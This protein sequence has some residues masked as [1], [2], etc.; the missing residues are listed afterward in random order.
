MYV[1]YVYGG[2]DRQIRFR[3]ASGTFIL[4]IWYTLVVSIISYANY[5]FSFP[6]YKVDGSWSVFSPYGNCSKD[7]GLGKQ[8]RQRSCTNPSPAHGG[9]KCIGEPAQ[10][11]ECK[12][13]EC[14][15]K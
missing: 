7:C 10:S 13:K 2:F 11:R 8:E 5:T 3:K 14:P 15:S 6:M 12:L 1:I 4:N 9:E